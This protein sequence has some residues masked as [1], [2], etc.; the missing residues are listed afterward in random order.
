MGNCIINV[1]DGNRA[2]FEVW[3][4]LIS[5]RV[6]GVLVA[7]RSKVLD[8]PSIHGTVGREFKSPHAQVSCLTC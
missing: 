1:G 2:F 3:P 6:L 7:E 5:Q 4:I 8:Q